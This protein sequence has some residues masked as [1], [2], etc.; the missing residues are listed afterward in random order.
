MNTKIGRS[1]KLAYFYLPIFRIWYLSEIT[2]S[3]IE[4]A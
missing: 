2:K 3:K 1:I 4:I